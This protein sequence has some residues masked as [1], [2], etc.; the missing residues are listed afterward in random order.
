MTPSPRILSAVLAGLSDIC[1]HTLDDASG[2]WF[3]GF[4]PRTIARAH[5]STLGLLTRAMT[6]ASRFKTGGR[7]SFTAAAEES[8]MTTRTTKPVRK[9]VQFNARFTETMNEELT[10]RAQ[11]RGVTGS[12]V[13]R[14]LVAAW[15]RN[16]S[17]VAVGFE[18]NS[19]AA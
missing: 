6:D 3:I 11:E 15:L 4:T 16:P 12:E 8:A 10:L 13:V 2:T 7:F 18:Q 9:T 5:R 14:A 1:V 17:T 19:A